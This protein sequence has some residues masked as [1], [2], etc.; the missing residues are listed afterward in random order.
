MAQKYSNEKVHLE[1][2]TFGQWTVL[3]RTGISKCGQSLW[4]CICSCG[5]EKP[6]VLY[7]ALTTGGSKS[8]G[9]LKNKEF[10][11][12]NRKHGLTKSQAPTYMVWLWIKT[13]CYNKQNKGY[14]QCGARGVV[15]KLSWSRSFGE[16]FQDVGARPTLQ[17]TLKRIDRNGNYEPGNVHWV[18]RKNTR[19]KTNS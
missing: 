14:D 1:G 13:K 19:I 15:M 8:C 12:R 9:C 5:V 16:F 3:E 4:R 10:G 7:G 11:D 2:R 6:K 17:H 18:A